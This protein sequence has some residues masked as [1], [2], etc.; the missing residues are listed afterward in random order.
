[1]ADMSKKVP[2]REQPP[3]KRA[4]NFEEVCYGYHQDEAMKEAARCLNCK[5]PK[6]VQGCPVGI[7]IPKFISELK[8]GDIEAAY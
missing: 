5:N 8:A 2:V 3:K 6:C 4:V 1:M 7:A